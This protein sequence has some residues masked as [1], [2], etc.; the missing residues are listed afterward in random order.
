MTL[1]IMQDLRPVLGPVRDQGR[2]PTC[3]SFAASA[4]HE[5]ARGDLDPL[6]VEWL[7][8]HAAQRANTGPDEGT[9]LPNTR[10]VL[11]DVGQPLEPIWP[12]NRQPTK[13]T[14]GPPSNVSSL[15]RCGSDG[16][17]TNVADIRELLDR[18]RPVVLALFISA[19]FTAATTWVRTGS[20]IILPEDSDPSDRQRGHAI[21]A[22]GHGRL[23]SEDL[24]LI[25]NSWGLAWGADGY[26]WVRE[27][28]LSRRLFGGFSISEGNGDVL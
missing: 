18:G 9:T 6:C 12:Y 20:E 14:W 7:F 10:Q 5:R 28:Y 19:A 17:G 13:E 4:A 26:A 16:C 22:V 24:I 27:T 1:H 3:L 21:V 25:R 23:G 8:Y 11:Y 15:F 2:R